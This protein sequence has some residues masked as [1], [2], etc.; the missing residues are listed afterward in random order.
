LIA[1]AI[2]NPLLAPERMSAIR[3]RQLFASHALFDRHSALL[4]V[5]REAALA[6]SI[7]GL[8]RWR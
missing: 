1:S 5:A 3:V 6:L 2:T 4:D 8:D 7:G